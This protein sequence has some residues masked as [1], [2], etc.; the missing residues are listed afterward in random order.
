MK[1]ARAELYAWDCRSPSGAQAWL[2]LETRLGGAEEQ[3]ELETTNLMK[4][5]RISTNSEAIGMGLRIKG[6]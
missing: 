6:Y 2:H 1:P 4:E 3:A 5:G